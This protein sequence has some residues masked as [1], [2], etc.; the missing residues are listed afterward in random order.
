MST[1]A[2]TPF[3]PAFT[4]LLAASTTPVNAA[5][6]GNGETMLVTNLSASPAYVKFSSDPAVQATTSDTP[7]LPNNR[8]LLRCGPLVTFC[9]A[10]L[11]SGTGSVLFTRG[12]GSVV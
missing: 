8:I 4:V 10:V 3:Q 1:G 11:I 6:T 7:V 5:L 9:A 12:D 2:I